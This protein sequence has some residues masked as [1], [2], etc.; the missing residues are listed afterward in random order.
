MSYARAQGDMYTGDTGYYRGDPGFFSGMF[1][2]SKR[3]FTNYVVPAAVG[4]YTGGL[5]G[6]LNAIGSRASGG[7]AQPQAGSVYPTQTRAPK[8]GQTQI[9]SKRAASM[10]YTMQNVAASGSIL[11]GLAKKG[12]ARLPEIAQA[13]M[14][15]GSPAQQVVDQGPT[16]IGGLPPRGHHFIKHG[17]H[18][19]QLTKNRRMNVTN[20]RALRRAIRRGHGF[21]KLAS[22]TIRFVAPKK[23]AKGFGG[24]KHRAKK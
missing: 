14:P 1:R 19:G 16:V 8:Y 9:V 12:I 13:F 7:V 23:K 2:S 3:L 22:H 4:Y 15:G 6:A 17:P 18:A 21:V 20:P 11:R 10:P 24:W 5:G